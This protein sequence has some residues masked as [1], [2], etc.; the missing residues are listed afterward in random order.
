MARADGVHYWDVN[1]KRYLDALSGIYVASVGHNNRR[2]IE[3]IKRQLDVLHFSPPM[4]GTNPAGRATGQPA[5]RARAGRPHT[6]KFQTRRL[7][8]HRGRHQ[9]RPAISPAD[10]QPGQ[11]QDHQPLSIVARLDP[12]LALGLGAEVAQDGERAAGRR[13]PA[14]LPA[15]VLPLPVRQGLPATAGSPAPRSSSDVIDMEDPATVAAIMVEPIGHTGGIIDPPD[16]Y[17]PILREI[18][19]RHNILLIFDEIIT[20]IGRT[21]QMFAAETFGVT[22]DVLCIGEGHE[23]RLCPDLGDDLPQA[24]RRCLLG[25]D[26]HESG[27]RGGPHIRRQPGRV[28]RGRL[29]CFRRSSSA[30]CAATP[31]S[32]GHRLRSRLRGAGREIRRDRRHPRQRA[33]PGHRIRPRPARPKTP[34]PPDS[35]SASASAG[36]PSSTACSAGSTP[37]GSPSARR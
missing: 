16:E 25:A 2:V 13:V 32:R 31:A 29:P 9:A 26:R 27:L 22:P 12:G 1:G 10:G 33:V 3:A 23:R 15:D 37:T 5:R 11:V 34:F 7:G 4:H 35:A 36:G 20:G 30:T 17:L 18:C 6:V 19:D 21:G 24:D 8:S 28:R 14:R